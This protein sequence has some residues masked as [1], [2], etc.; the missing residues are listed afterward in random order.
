MAEREMSGKALLD[1]LYGGLDTMPAAEAE[2]E[3]RAGDL[4]SL[5]DDFL[6]KPR[7]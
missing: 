2:A 7:S 1:K 5:T 3:L 6:G 4:R